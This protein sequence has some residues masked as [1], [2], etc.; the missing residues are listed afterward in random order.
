MRKYFDAAYVDGYQNG[1]LSLDL[2]RRDVRAVPLYFVWGSDSDMPTFED[3]EEELARAPELHRAATAEAERLASH[4]ADGLVVQHT[5]FLDVDGYSA[6][7]TRTRSR[8][9]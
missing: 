3:F 2:S 1:L 7:A 8:R 4:M 5:P 6:A 9:T